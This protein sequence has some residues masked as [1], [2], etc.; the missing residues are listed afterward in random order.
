MVDAIEMSYLDALA[1]S[2]LDLQS[3][4]AL[5]R[6][7][8]EGKHDTLLTERMK[9][10]LGLHKNK[11]AQFKMNL[12]RS[13]VTAI[14]ERL[15]VSG[16]DSTEPADAEG[17]KLQA[18]WAWDLWQANRMDAIQ[19]DVHDQAL[20]SGEHFVIVD[21][22]AAKRRPHFTPTPRYT[23]TT[24]GGDGYGVLMVYPDGDIYSDPLYAV[25]QWTE[26]IVIG[27]ERRSR[28]RR[29]LYYPERIERYVRGD[30]GGTWREYEGVPPA[31]AWPLPWIGSDGLPLGIP[32]AHFRNK[33]LRPEALDIV[34]MQDAGNKT[35]ID[36]L[37]SADV[38]AFRIF[39]AFGFFPTSDGKEPKTDGSNAQRIAPGQIIGSTK[40]PQDASFDAIE[41]GD[42]SQISEVL[43]Q[44]VL[45]TAIVSYTPASRFM[46][47]R[48]VSS[49][50][51]LREQREPLEA[52]VVNRQTLFG[53]GWEDVMSISRRLSNHFGQAGLDESQRLTTLW[54][55]RQTLEDVAAKRQ[56]GVPEE[57]L[58]IEAGYTQEE[59]AA[60]K[61]TDEY[62]AR[63]MMRQIGLGGEG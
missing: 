62:R 63:S 61:E 12:I 11:R 3:D 16:F 60:M 48:Q 2:E 53:N 26:T 50:E 28:Q 57:Q 54:S 35:L 56:L 55:S 23:D 6:R 34:P 40:G 46:Q 17:V 15:L 39:K 20:V 47:T 30:G 18:Q 51:A 7:Y 1:Q 9:E 27:G 41:A 45:L 22:D 19:V 49:A 21:W 58:W 4:I 37:A 29:T 24:A 14:S 25:K 52:K 43:S 32:V 31:T 33:D 44:L 5:C 42:L 36:L 59:I 13:V 38:S 10:F 8:H